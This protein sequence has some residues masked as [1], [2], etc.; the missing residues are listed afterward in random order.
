MTPYQ[1]ALGHDEITEA[2]MIGSEPERT[3]SGLLGK[4]GMVTLGVVVGTVATVYVATLLTAMAGNAL[5]QE[6]RRLYHQQRGRRVSLIEDD[7]TLYEYA[8]EPKA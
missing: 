3:S 6:S 4:V 7:S 8:V 2:D 5:F 1:R